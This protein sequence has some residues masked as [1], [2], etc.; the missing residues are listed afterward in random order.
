MAAGIPGFHEA[1]AGEG[2][3]RDMAGIVAGVFTS[4]LPTS[5]VGAHP[6]RY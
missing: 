5:G 1:R 2:V 4:E 3:Y 6:S